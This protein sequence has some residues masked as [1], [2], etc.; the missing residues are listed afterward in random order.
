MNR[1]IVGLAVFALAGC[2]AVTVNL[3]E[4]SAVAFESPLQ[5]ESPLYVVSPLET[6]T[7]V[8][9]G[10]FEPTVTATMVSD[11]VTPTPWWIDRPTVEPGIERYELIFPLMFGGGE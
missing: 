4:P 2:I 8:A 6:P 5:G 9:T 3:P 11:L 7:I 10:V 1:L